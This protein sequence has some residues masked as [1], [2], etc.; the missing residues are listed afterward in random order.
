MKKLCSRSKCRRQ[1]PEGELT[2][3][4]CTDLPDWCGT[5][6]R[7]NPDAEIVDGNPG[8]PDTC[9]NGHRLSHDTDY[10]GTHFEWCDVC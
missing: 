8:V 4:H 2:C 1:I 3:P 5:R 10:N 6:R 9:P 7:A